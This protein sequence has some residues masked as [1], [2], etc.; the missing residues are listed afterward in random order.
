MLF[1][2]KDDTELSVMIF[3]YRSCWW[4]VPHWKGNHLGDNERWGHKFDTSNVLTRADFSSTE[5]PP[6]FIS[7]NNYRLT[8]HVLPVNLRVSESHTYLFTTLRMGIYLQKKTPTPETSCFIPHHHTDLLN[9]NKTNEGILGPGTIL[10]S[11]SLKRTFIFFAV[12]ISYYKCVVY[13]LWLLRYL[14]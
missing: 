11:N 1:L 3:S 13:C 10:H 6:G 2:Y 12:R 14:I 7:L 9:E 8:R 5:L 4:Y